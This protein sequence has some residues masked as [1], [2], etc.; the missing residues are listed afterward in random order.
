MSPYG[1]AR[2]SPPASLESASDASQRAAERSQALK[3]WFAKRA[4]APRN[5]DLTRLL[6]WTN[7]EL[8]RQLGWVRL[9]REICLGPLPLRPLVLAG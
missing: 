1:S 3:V 4:P 7:P 6:G 2:R 5:D 9:V 8:R